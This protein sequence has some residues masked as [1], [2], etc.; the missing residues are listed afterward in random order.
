MYKH[1]KIGINPENKQK[2]FYEIEKNL[3]SRI[4]SINLTEKKLAFKFVIFWYHYIMHD[5]PCFIGNSTNEINN[6]GIKNIFADNGYFKL[7]Q[8]LFNNKN[9]KGWGL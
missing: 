7:F 6:I 1:L 2:Y 5:F 4:E 9:T 8:N 3:K